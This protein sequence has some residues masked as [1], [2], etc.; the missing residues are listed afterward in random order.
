MQNQTEEQFFLQYLLT[1]QN[2]SHLL[3][4]FLSPAV[5]WLFIFKCWSW[6]IPRSV[7]RLCGVLPLRHLPDESSSTIHQPT[8][9]LTTL[10][11]ECALHIM[12]L[13]FP[14]R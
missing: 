10:Q 12:D 8:N 2:F 9:V 13:Q 4:V 5:F 7:D 6:Y 11:L 3:N 1:L 14:K